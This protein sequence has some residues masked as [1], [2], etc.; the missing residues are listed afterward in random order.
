MVITMDK[1]GKMINSRAT[2]QTSIVADNR[3]ESAKALLDYG[4]VSGLVKLVGHPAQKHEFKD[5]L[6]NL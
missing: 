2:D 3:R 6:V 1:D 4:F 5:G